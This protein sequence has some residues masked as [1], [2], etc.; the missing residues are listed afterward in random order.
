MATTLSSSDSAGPNRAAVVGTLGRVEIDR[1]WYAP[2]TLRVYDAEN[3]LIET[4]DGAVP[5]RGM[6]FQAFEVERLVASGG[7][8]TVMPPRQSVAIM[9]CLDEIRRQIGLTY[10]GEA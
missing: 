10:P 6:Q 8:S 4:F 3:R 1:T 9:R 2:T 5:G 7:S